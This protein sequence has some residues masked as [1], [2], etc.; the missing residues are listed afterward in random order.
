MGL[1]DLVGGQ[2]TQKLI[3]KINSLRAELELK[4]QKIEEAKSAAREAKEA[5]K[6]AKGERAGLQ[7]DLKQEQRKNRNLKDAKKALEERLDSAL[8]DLEASKAKASRASLQVGELEERV[9][10]LEGMSGELEE[11]KSAQGA[12]TRQLQDAERSAEL[13]P[14]EAELH[15]KIDMM[16]KTHT[17]L[18]D[19]IAGLKSRLR[20]AEAERETLRQEK[21]NAAVR[22]STDLRNLKHYLILERRAYLMQ[23]QELELAQDR[24]LGAEQ[25]FEIK[26]KEAIES[27]RAEARSFVDAERQTALEEAQAEAQ[28]LRAELRSLVARGPAQV[29]VAEVVEYDE[30]R[31][32]AERRRVQEAV[33]EASKKEPVAEEPVAEAPV[34]EEPVTETPVA[35]EPVAE[36]PVAEAPVSE[37][38]VATEPVA[39]EPVAEEPVATEPVAEAPMAEEPVAEAPVEEEPALEGEPTPVTA[40]FV[41]DTEGTEEGTEEG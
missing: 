9:T 4:S 14:T 17:L 40:T 37:E 21:A 11:L 34:A 28:A 20:K 31:A 35:E 39:E 22:L 33:Q 8:A 29:P 41:A 15:D 24:A 38:P 26:T 19:E 2:K 23:S 36:A 25:R 32:R 13:A 3:E 18:R 16:G 1:F 12:L 5:M 7:G 27:A 6:K 30:E 10:E